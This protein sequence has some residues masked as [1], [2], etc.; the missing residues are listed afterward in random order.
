MAV[1]HQESASVCCHALTVQDQVY[2]NLVRTWIF[3][4]AV[5]KSQCIQMIMID[6]NLMAKIWTK[7][8]MSQDKPDNAENIETL[9]VTSSKNAC[10]QC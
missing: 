8:I 6:I 4:N 3:A 5:I 1:E 7:M 9:M 2:E 10:N